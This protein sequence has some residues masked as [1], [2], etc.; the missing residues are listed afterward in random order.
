METKRE[1][2][3]NLSNGFEK[4]SLTGRLCYLF[5]CIEKY[6]TTCYSDRDW[7]PVAQR[8]WQWT[9]IYWDEGSDMYAPVVPE[10]LLEFDTYQETNIKSFDGKL[11]EKEY[12]ILKDL[13]NGITNGSADDE[14]NLVLML[15]IDFN[16]ACECSA[17]SDANEITLMIIDEMQ[18]F[19]SLHNISFPDMNKVRHM[20]VDA[21]NGW[22]N[23]FDSKYLSIII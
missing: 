7:T 22:G 13:Y 9:N 11:S 2:M 4:L 17:F 12:L 8:L 6:L 3:K 18:Q 23:F 5:M 14:I 15:P 21:K 10:F 20:T 16:N 1:I 19:L